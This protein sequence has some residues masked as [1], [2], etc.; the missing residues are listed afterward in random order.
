MNT[1][2]HSYNQLKASGQIKYQRYL[3]DKKRLVLVSLYS[4]LAF[5][6][7]FSRRSISKYDK[8]LHQH[9]QKR[10][11]LSGLFFSGGFLEFF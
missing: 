10:P 5:I 11:E 4:F 7:L 3:N 1:I 9:Q 8:K 6:E 2:E